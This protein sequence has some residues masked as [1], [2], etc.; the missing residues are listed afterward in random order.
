MIK[1]TLKDFLQGKYIDKT[2]YD[3]K[4]FLYLNDVQIADT[5]QHIKD[6]ERNFN[7]DCTYIE[8]RYN[9][10][11]DYKTYIDKEISNG[12]FNLLKYKKITRKESNDISK[13]LE[14]KILNAETHEELEAV[15]IDFDNYYNNMMELPEREEDQT[16]L[17]DRKQKVYDWFYDNL[18]NLYHEKY[19]TDMFFEKLLLN[20]ENKLTDATSTS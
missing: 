8:K 4:Q 10:I 12:L 16:F 3:E 1:T 11:R 9:K 2:T 5:L 13:D 6:I 15:L 19:I 18:K 7:V 20:Y 14:K 17:N